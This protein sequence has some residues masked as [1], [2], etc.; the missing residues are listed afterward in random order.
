MGLIRKRFSERRSFAKIY[1]P[2]SRN[3]IKSSKRTLH[4]KEAMDRVATGKATAKAMVLMG[5]AMELG[6][7]VHQA[8]AQHRAL[9]LRHRPVLLEHLELQARPPLMAMK[10]HT[11][12]MV[13]MP[14]MWPGTLTTLSNNSRPLPGHPQVRQAMHLHLL[15]RVDLHQPMEVTML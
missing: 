9:F 3:N 1:L 5:V 12:R 7:V 14:T 10:T 8:T 11:L 4:N 15:P 6:M 13:A 2:T